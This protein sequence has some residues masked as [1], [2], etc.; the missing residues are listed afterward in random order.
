M[1]SGGVV[2][3]TDLTDNAWHHIVF[4]Q[5]DGTIYLIVDGLLQASAVSVGP[6]NNSSSNLALGGFG[7][8][9]NN[10]L[11]GSLD[12]VSFWNYALSSAELYSLANAQ[13]PY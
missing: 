7:E 1:G 4:I 8:Y 6:V 5:K 13:Y 12:A 11:S 2:G 9:A 10:Y 3:N